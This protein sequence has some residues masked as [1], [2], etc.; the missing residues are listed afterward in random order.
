MD[1]NWVK[2]R[3]FGKTKFVA[4]FS[5]L[6]GVALAFG[7]N[8]VNMIMESSFTWYSIISIATLGMFF[9]GMLGG[10]LAGLSQWYIHEEKFSK[11]QQSV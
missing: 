7:G 6:F 5:L 3:K 11:E 4:A 1:K 8:I 9:G 10:L 2:I